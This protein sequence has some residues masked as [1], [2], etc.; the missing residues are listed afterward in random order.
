[1]LYE[2]RLWFYDVCCMTTHNTVRGVELLTNRR[3]ELRITG[4]QVASIGPWEGESDEVVWVAPAFTDAQCNGY[5]GNDYSAADLNA[6]H[7]GQVVSVLAR[8]GTGLHLPTVITNSQ[9]RICRNLEIIADAVERNE[10]VREA[11]GGIHVEGPYISDQDGPRGAHDAA[12]V[13]DPSYAEVREWMD[14]SAGLLRMVTLAPERRGALEVIERL[15]AD[16][17]IVAIGHT[18]ASPEQIRCAVDA[19]AR[20][21][22]HLGNGSHGQLPRLK[23]YLWAQLSDDRLAAG[24]IADGFHLP[25]DVLRVFGRVKSADR[26]FLVS[27]AAYLGGTAPGTYHWGTIAVDVHEDGHLGLHGTEFLAGAGHL[28]DRGVIVAARA[29]NLS[30]A[31]AVRACT[32]VPNTLL[33]LRPHPHSL[34]WFEAPAPGDH[35]LRIRGTAIAG[36]V[37]YQAADTVRPEVLRA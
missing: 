32:E 7:V 36:R 19:G 8:S 5:A 15:T 11:V 33:G 2:I 28:L 37:V 20:V 27:D 14:A 29:M 24:V 23:N 1:M 30:L 13:R 12:F 10:L 22:T 17:V 16:G 35:A 6:E 9:E 3:V 34:T 21:S 18:A 25:D 4:D 26:I 31:D